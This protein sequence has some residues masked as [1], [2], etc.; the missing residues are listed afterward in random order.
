MNGN[1]PTETMFAPLQVKENGA[2]KKSLGTLGQQIEESKQV[3]QQVFSEMR[4]R[5]A[6]LNYNR[7]AWD[8]RK[9]FDT[10]RSKE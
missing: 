6:R 10:P 8:S 1:L 7:R 2:I 4:S 9:A 5:S 3:S